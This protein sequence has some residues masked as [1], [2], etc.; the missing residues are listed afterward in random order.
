MQITNGAPSCVGLNL[1]KDYKLALKDIFQTQ[2]VMIVKT[3]VASVAHTNA[4]DV[5][6]P[7]R[8][9]AKSKVRHV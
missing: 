6:A 4:K 9:Y 5:I 1:S 8:L 3:K 2:Q 7:L